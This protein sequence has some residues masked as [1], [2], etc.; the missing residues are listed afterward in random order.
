MQWEITA[1]E[2]IGLVV[3]KKDNLGRD[4][5]KSEKIGTSDEAHLRQDGL[6]DVPIELTQ[7]EI[8]YLSLEAHRREMTFNDIIV[9]I[10]E[11]EIKRIEN[12]AEAKVS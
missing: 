11:N 8:V 3:T 1:M 2:K 6:W 9:E 5:L 10:L 12:E 4:Y 7:D